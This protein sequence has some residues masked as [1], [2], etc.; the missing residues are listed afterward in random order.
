[1]KLFSAK[2]GLKILFV[3]PEASP[4]AKVGGLGSVMYS[5]PKALQH[6]GHDARVMIPRY[7]SIEE[8]KFD[9][10][11]TVEH[12]EV[13]TGNK[14]GPATLICNVKKYSPKTEEDPV[15][16]YFLENQEYYEL[17]ANVYGYGDDPVRWA[18][19]CRGV[20][21]F[22]RL[23]T[24]WTPDIIV[25]ADWG[26]GY[27]PNFARTI[28]KDDPVISKIRTVFAIHNLYHQGMFDHKFVNEMDYDDGHSP[29]PAFE[30]ERLGKINALRRGIM[31]ADAIT[32]V[33]PTYAKEILT[34]DFGEM[35]DEL[36]KERRGVLQGIL[37]GIDYEYWN[38][39]TD[40]YVIHHY[41][42]TTLE[43]RLKNKQVLQE[44]FNLPANKNTFVIGIVSRLSAQKGFDLFKHIADTL[45]QELPMQLI[46]VGEGDGEI[47]SFFKDLEA[48]YPQ[49][50]ATHLKFDNVLPHLMYAGADAVLVPSKFEPSGLTQ[51][52]AMRMGAIPIVRKTG[53]LADSVEDYNPN[54]QS[55][56]GFVFERFDSSSLMIALIRAFENY[57]DKKNWQGLQKRAMAQ[58]FSWD[59]S[60][61]KYIEFF[62]RAIQFNK[63]NT[64]EK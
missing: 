56:T 34:K 15:T 20:L 41:G 28:Y 24:H 26:M 58:D 21:E 22:L 27:L 9:L 1:M 4:F 63:R 59:S 49:K 23:D 10:E 30:D 39:K 18:L 13:P 44:R 6:L 17:R 8:T 29:I 62:E 35:L 48:R 60:A 37:N 5:L 64:P 7:V 51:M 46:V 40:P 14:N 16:T 61:K 11:M 42:P 33:S 55:G 43:T 57:R 52:E 38:P 45:L 2:T 25:A 31:C 12:L 32:T 19:L 54:K 36:L 47:M 50:V 53:G 3:A